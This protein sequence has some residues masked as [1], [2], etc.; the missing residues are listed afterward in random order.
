MSKI[1][2]IS[3]NKGGV[4]KSTI[5]INLAGYLSKNKSTY[6]IDMD[7]QGSVSSWYQIRKNNNIKNAN[8]HLSENPFTMENIKDNIDSLDKKHDFIIIDCP[9]EDAKIMRF[10]L[11]I[12]DYTIIPVAPTPFDIRSA[13]VTV[14]TIKEGLKHKMIN[15]KPRLLISR[16]IT[17][18]ILGQEAK[19]TLKV[20]KIP[21]F[22]SEISQRIAIAESGI[23]GYT[24]FEY[25]P[26]CK[27]SQEF[28]KLGKEFIKWQKK[29]NQD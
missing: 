14:N 25:N 15:T 11:S 8:L 9:P 7:P 12:S 6:L 22:K 26:N 4:G 16:K 29:Q 27:A 10:S 2:S 23:D 19:K 20:F 13:Y 1:I 18:T 21:I 5:A 24:I 28:N 3:N 17:G